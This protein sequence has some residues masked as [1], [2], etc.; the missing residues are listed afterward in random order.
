MESIIVLELM[1]CHSLKQENV[2]SDGTMT[3]LLN[4]NTS[5]HN[6]AVQLCPTQ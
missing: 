6:S 2:Y 5:C 4:T 1:M 3:T